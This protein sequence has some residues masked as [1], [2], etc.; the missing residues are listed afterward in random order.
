MHT[1][2]KETLRPAWMGWLGAVSAMLAMTAVFWLFTWLMRAF[3]KMSGTVFFLA[4]LFGMGLAGLCALLGVEWLCLKNHSRRG[5]AYALFLTLGMAA[6][7]V[8]LL[9]MLRG[10][11]AFDSINVLVLWVLL[12]VFSAA[13]T[14]YYLAWRTAEHLLNRQKK[15]YVPMG[16]VYVGLYCFL[17]AAYLCI[18]GMA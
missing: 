5:R 3:P 17:L 14:V 10:C 16:A 6:M 15:V 13:L 9:V 4:M 18:L 11:G 2:W 1:N 7:S 8:G 12:A